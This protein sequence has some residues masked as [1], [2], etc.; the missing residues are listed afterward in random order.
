MKKLLIVALSWLFPVT[1]P[2]FAQSLQ[3]HVQAMQGA[4]AASGSIVA[5]DQS[6]L[7]IEPNMPGPV[8]ALPSNQG[9]KITWTYYAFP[10]ASIT[11]PLS[12]VD[13]DLMSEDIV[14]TKPDGIKAYK[15]GDVGDTTMVIIAGVAGAQFHTMVYDREKLLRLPPGVHQSSAYGQAPDDVEVFGLT[16]PDHASARAFVSAFRDAVMLARAQAARH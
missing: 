16:F 2:C 1:A 13:P 10:L 5:L 14:F 4:Y 7:V 3:S 11:V 15:P 6:T 8:C 12:A 9:G